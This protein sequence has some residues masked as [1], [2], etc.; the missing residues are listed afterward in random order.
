MRFI[1]GL[2]AIL[3]VAVFAGCGSSNTENHDGFN[4]WNPDQTDWNDASYDVGADADGP[5]A[6]DSGPDGGGDAALDSEFLDGSTDSLEED[7]G[8]DAPPLSFFTPGHVFV[9]GSR[10][11]EVFEFNEILELVSRWTH[12]MFGEVLPAPGQSLHL[13]PQGMAFDSDGRLVVATLS[14]FCVFSAPDEVFECY[15]K[16]RDQATENIIFDSIGNLYT[17]T[18]TGG[19]NE[20]HKYTADYE[21]LTTFS[22]PTGELTGITCDPSSNLYVAS[23]TGG[24]IYK[25][26]REDLSVL[27]T[28]PVAGSLEGLQFFESD[29]IFVA[30]HGGVPTIQLVRASSPAELLSSGTV[31]GCAIPVPITTDDA[32]RIYVADYENGSGTAPADLFLVSADGTVIASYLASP[33]YGPFGMV[34]AGVV[35]PCGAYQ[36]E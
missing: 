25:F 9:A 34:V 29:S 30:A 33:V 15:P 2:A 21:Y 26:D 18:A 4:D 27:D 3:I 16:V 28:I 14:H 10:N 19:T 20:V 32:G 6:T 5:D 13:G 17:T 31:A 11:A 36:L 35:L 1:S 12:P 23:Q 22:A 7:G 8:S 24:C